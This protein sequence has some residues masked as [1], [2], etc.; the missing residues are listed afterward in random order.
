MDLIKRFSYFPPLHAN[1]REKR[2][3]SAF[4]LKT[5]NLLNDK[6]IFQAFFSLNRCPHF[7][8]KNRAKTC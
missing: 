4:A 5:E 7:L 8:I 2:P 6:G 3:L 1:V